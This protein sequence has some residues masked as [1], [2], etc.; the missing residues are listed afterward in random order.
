MIEQSIMVYRYINSIREYLVTVM[1]CGCLADSGILTDNTELQRQALVKT[2]AD[3]HESRIGALTLLVFSTVALFA[4][5]LLP[6]L[7]SARKYFTMR[8]LWITSHGVF[9]LSMLG[10]FVIRSTTGTILLF[11]TVG[12][13]WA[14]SVWIPYAL[15]GAETSSPSTPRQGSSLVTTNEDD[16]DEEKYRGGDGAY[17]DDDM[18]LSDQSGLI[19]GVHNFFICLPQ[20]LINLEMGVQWMLSA[21]DKGGDDEQDLGLVWVLRLGGVFALMAMYIATGIRE[22]V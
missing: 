10:T 12:Y 15:L 16:V 19:Y 21:V 3:R 22:P 5:L 4:A 2:A 6:A 17:G 1:I 20:F 11:G 9:G 18:D 14:V 7:V 8:Q 13:S